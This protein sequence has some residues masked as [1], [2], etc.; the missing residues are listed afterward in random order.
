MRRALAI[1]AMGA[2]VAL[3]T[4]PAWAG[5]NSGSPDFP[6]LP[7]VVTA[8]NVDTSGT[9]AGPNSEGNGPYYNFRLDNQGK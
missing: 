6:N 4:L 8:D 1:L 2:G 5:E 9:V 3:A 7:T